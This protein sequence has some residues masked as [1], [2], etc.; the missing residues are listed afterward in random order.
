MSA[1]N[2]KPLWFV[3]FCL[4]I[5]IVPKGG[6]DHYIVCVEVYVVVF[7]VGGGGCWGEGKVFYIGK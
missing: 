3:L 5:T 4:E 7:L 6:V 2:Y 1:Q